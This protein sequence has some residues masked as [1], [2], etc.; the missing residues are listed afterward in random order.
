MVVRSG[1]GVVDVAILDFL[2]HQWGVSSLR[3]DEG[4]V[5]R[6][7]PRDS[8]MDLRLSSPDRRPAEKGFSTMA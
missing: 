5:C 1:V 3:G 8:D 7:R 4:M 2:T 6:A